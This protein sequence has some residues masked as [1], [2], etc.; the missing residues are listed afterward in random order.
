MG[1][2]R[3][4]GYLTVMGIGGEGVDKLVVVE[5]GDHRDLA[6]YVGQ[7]A[8]ITASPAAQPDAGQPDAGRLGRPDAG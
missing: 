2:A 8:V 5:E 6:A 1:R 3:H 4:V 7:C